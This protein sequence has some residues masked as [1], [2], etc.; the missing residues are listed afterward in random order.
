MKVDIP[1]TLSC[2]CRSANLA[3][4]LFNKNGKVWRD[5]LKNRMVWLD[6]VCSDVFYCIRMDLNLPEAINMIIALD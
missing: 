5:K 6:K 2:N 4:V 3:V 1:C